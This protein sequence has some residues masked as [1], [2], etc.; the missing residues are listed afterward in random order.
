[1]VNDPQSDTETKIKFFPNFKTEEFILYARPV[2]EYA[3]TVFYEIYLR[4]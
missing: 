2:F 4:I 3:M 1:M